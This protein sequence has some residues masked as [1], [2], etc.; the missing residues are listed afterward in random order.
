MITNN[1]NLKYL[2]YKILFVQK[3]EV[4]KNFQC[5]M[6]VALSIGSCVLELR[7]KDILKADA[8]EGCSITWSAY[9]SHATPKSKGKIKGVLSN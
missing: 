5:I 8:T 9:N 2:S 4:F 3:K 1:S 7:D 6:F